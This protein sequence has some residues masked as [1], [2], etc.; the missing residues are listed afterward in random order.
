M[1]VVKSNTVEYEPFYKTL[2]NLAAEEDEGY[3][4]ISLISHKKET[5][6]NNNSLLDD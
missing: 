5:N 1:R 6:G 2:Q 3:N 4:P